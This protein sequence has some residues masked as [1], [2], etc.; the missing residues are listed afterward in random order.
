MNGQILHHLGVMGNISKLSGPF[1]REKPLFDLIHS[2]VL[3]P[4]VADT[5][6]LACSGVLVPD[7]GQSLTSAQVIFPF[8]FCLPG[9]VHCL[10]PMGPVSWNCSG[11]AWSSSTAQAALFCP[12]LSQVCMCAAG[13]WQHKQILSFNSNLWN[14][15]KVPSNIL[16]AYDISVHKTEKKWTLAQ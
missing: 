3:P 5:T 7:L 9:N 16:D 4:G 15:Y 10:L 14:V 8:Q 2:L 11:P 6:A 13:P 1:L 12:L